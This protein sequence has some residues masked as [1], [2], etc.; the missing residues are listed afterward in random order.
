MAS[1]CRPLRT[2]RVLTQ[3]MRVC[4]YD[5]AMICVCGCVHLCAGT[6]HL[7][8]SAYDF[9]CLLCFTAAAAAVSCRLY[10]TVPKVLEL[11]SHSKFVWTASMRVLALHMRVCDVCAMICKHVAYATAAVLLKVNT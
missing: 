4:C 7:F 2:V 1:L 8:V 3:H 11:S 5:C 10:H 9:F 6:P